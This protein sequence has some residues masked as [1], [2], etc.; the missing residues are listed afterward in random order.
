MPN[1]SIA[2][3]VSATV[4][5]TDTTLFPRDVCP[6]LEDLIEELNFAIGVF[7]VLKRSLSRINLQEFLKYTNRIEKYILLELTIPN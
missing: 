7:Y 1:L 2:S 3:D 5:R 6:A 4:T